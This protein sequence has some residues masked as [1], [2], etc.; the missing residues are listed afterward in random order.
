MRK[1]LTMIMSL[2][3]L[4]SLLLASCS[5]ETSAPATRTVVDSIGRSVEIPYEVHKVATLVGPSYDKVFMLGEKDRIAMVGFAQSPWAQHL[6]PDLAN[7]STATNAKSPNIEELLNLGIEV[8]FT[9]STT[10]PLEAMS[11]A[12][13]PALAALASST[14][15]TSVEMYIAGMKGEVNLYAEVLGPAAKTRAAE[16]CEYLDNVIERIT[17]VTSRLAENE[18]PK[19]YY[20]RGPEVLST[21]GKYS[22]TRWYVE[23]AGGNMVSKDL[24]PVIAQVDI[25]QVIAWDPDIIMMGRLDSTD[26]VTSNPAWSAITAVKTGKVYV[27]PHG[28]FYWDY[29]TEGALFLMYLANTF[30][31]DKFADINMVKEVKDF[32]SQFYGYQLT[33]EQTNKILQHMAP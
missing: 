7:I 33:D 19:V 6:N 23:M 29:G 14:T 11:N 16:Y 20:V 25:E 2:V 8:V 12:G 22:N 32:Y 21:H 13:I 9:W 10:E 28:V 15:P 26:P 30:H 27:N 3:V 17:S 1:I 18:K 24:E 5:P 4:L 31:P